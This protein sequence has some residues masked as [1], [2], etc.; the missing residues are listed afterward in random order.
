[1]PN[2]FISFALTRVL[3]LSIIAVLFIS[4]LPLPSFAASD[5]N[6]TV[7]PLF[8]KKNA[9]SQ[10]LDSL[11][12]LK[13]SKKREGRTISEIELKQ[14]QLID[15]LQLIRKIIQS[16]IED[17]SQ[18]SDNKNGFSLFRLL[19]FSDLVIPVI[20]VI[21]LF[22]GI[23]FLFGAVKKALFRSSKNIIRNKPDNLN[24][25]PLNHQNS[26]LSGEFS[27]RS[28]IAESPQ[29]TNEEQIE[30]TGKNPD[31]F[32]DKNDEDLETKVIKAASEGM[33]IQELS[34]RFHLSSD[35]VTLILKL[36]ESRKK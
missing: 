16:D 11:D 19:K 5:H 10:S 4:S 27:N 31:Q 13:Q 9:L 17:A 14:K 34:R 35:H 20:A 6:S 36:A 15:S 32:D 12:L 7:I 24:T 3:K 22:T 29:E 8:Q 25:L 1:M 28:N 18:Q 21:L 26:L 2:A 30:C 33:S 23:L